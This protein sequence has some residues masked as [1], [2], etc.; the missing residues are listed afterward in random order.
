M[1]KIKKKAS[2]TKRG[3]KLKARVR[4]EAPAKLATNHNL[5]KKALQQL[6]RKPLKL[7][8]RVRGGGAPAK[9]GANHNLTVR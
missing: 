9:L 2:S 8:T 7:K 4:G 1:Q 6:T 5:T 3:Q